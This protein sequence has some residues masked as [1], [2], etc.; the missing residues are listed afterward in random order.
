MNDAERRELV[1][2]RLNK[3]KA[4]IN[5][6]DLHIQ[7]ELW[8]TSVNRIYYACYYAVSALLINSAVKAQTHAG[9]RQMFGLHFVK[10]GKIEIDLGKFYTD[11]FDKRMSGDY[12]DFVDFQKEEVLELYSQA[13]QLVTRI[14]QILES[15][16]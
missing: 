16:V 5:E 4:T 11:I 7:N 2:Y 8:N 10:S 9:V 14:I 6:I 1:T 3:A 13:D 12:E 15:S